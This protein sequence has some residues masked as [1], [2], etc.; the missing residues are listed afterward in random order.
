L[1]LKKP[2]A[3]AELLAWVRILDQLQIDVEHLQPGQKEAL[4]FSFSALAKNKE[5][6]E[7]LRKSI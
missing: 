2:P 5:D 6:L 1:A 4:A 7:R 3:T